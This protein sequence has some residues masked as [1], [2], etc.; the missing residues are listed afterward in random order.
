[1]SDNTNSSPSPAKELVDNLLYPPVKNLT[2]YQSARRLFSSDEK[3]RDWLNA[4]ESPFCNDYQ[5]T[6]DSLNRYPDCQPEGLKRAYA[7]YAGTQADN[8][9]ISRGADEGIE[10]LIRAFCTPGTD[11]IL[12][13]PPTYG[14]YQISAETFNIGVKTVPL[15]KEFQLDTDGIQQQLEQVKLIF[16]CSP[17]NPTGGV[18]SEQKL[19][20]IL[21]A[22]DG[23]ALVV[24]DEAYIEF[25]L[26]TNKVQELER[27]PNLVILR[28]LSKAFALAGLRCGFTLAAPPIIQA[29]LKVIAPYPVPLPVA[30]IAEQAL[31]AQ[32]LLRCEQQ[33]DSLKQ[34]Q[35]WLLGELEKISSIQPLGATAANFLLIRCQDQPELMAYLVAADVLVRDQSK[36]RYLQNCLRISIGSPE[37]NQRL[38]NTINQ[39]YQ[40][41]NNA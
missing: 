10:L 12:I 18:V 2:P 24:V 33:V 19:D 38:V 3:D 6:Q 11:N 26:P 29:L 32:G 23:K 40:Q 17:N 28:T 16:I 36:Q 30:D 37:Q 15:T 39:F 41:E 14:M 5:L 4:N 27:Y 35:T 21:Q 25:A 34:Q 31:S 22:A 20:T 13:C 1:M 9:L 8:V 7:T